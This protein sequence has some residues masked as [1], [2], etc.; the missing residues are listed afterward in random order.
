MTSQ[1]T[2]DK[3][4]RT[5]DNSVNN[6]I[7]GLSPIQQQTYKKLIELIKTLEIN[8]DGT[9][10]NNLAN[11]KVVG[12]LKSELENIVLSDNYVSHVSDFVDTYNNV[13]ELQNIYFSVTAVKFVEKRLYDEVTKQAIETTVSDLTE[14]GIGAN[15][16]DELKQIL[17]T[18]ITSGGSYVDL[19]KQLSD[20]V[21]GDTENDGSLIQYGRQIA[22]DGINQFNAQ[23]NRVVSDDLGMTWFQYLGSLLT[24]SRPF[25]KDMVQKRYFHISEVPDML[26]GHIGDKNVYI[27]KN[28]GLPDGFIDGTNKQSFF[29]NRGGYNCGHQ[30]FAV[31]LSLVPQALRDKFR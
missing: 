2:I 17:T 20:Y 14:S 3:L 18:N 28:T 26:H 7:D 11:I 9:L 1:E 6:F 31:P 5:I 13:Q 8:T 29:I 19:T 23:Y 12:S 22:T 30:I 21:L 27:N 24:T 25:C 15:Y 16:I 10:K 4:L